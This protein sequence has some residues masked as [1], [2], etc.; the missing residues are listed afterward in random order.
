MLEKGI[1][2]QLTQEIITCG[3]PISCDTEA[4]NL[5]D[6]IR[7]REITIAIVDKKDLI[8]LYITIEILLERIFETSNAAALAVFLVELQWIVQEALDEIND[9]LNL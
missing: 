5:R 3:Y 4:N 2:E 8:K 9:E 7:Q 1:A 6:G